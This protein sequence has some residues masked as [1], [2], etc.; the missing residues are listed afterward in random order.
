M[1]FVHLATPGFCP[2]CLIRIRREEGCKTSAVVMCG[3]CCDCVVVTFFCYLI[4]NAVMLRSCPCIAKKHFI[5]YY[6]IGWRDT[7]PVIAQH[8]LQYDPSMSS[9]DIDILQVS[10]LLC[11]TSPLLPKD[12]TFDIYFNTNSLFHPRSNVFHT[13]THSHIHTHSPTHTHTPTPTHTQ[14]VHKIYILL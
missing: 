12:Q 14:A 4:L 2:Q 9:N 10:S 1:T 6:R 3:T 5:K 7:C 8:T 11:L 13:D